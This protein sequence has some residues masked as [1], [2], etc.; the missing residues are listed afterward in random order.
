MNRTA[1][2]GIALLLVACSAPS[3]PGASQ[4]TA[5]LASNSRTFV[6]TAAEGQRGESIIKFDHQCDGVRHQRKVREHI[7]L[8]PDGGARWEIWIEQLMDGALAGST[9]LDL[10][11]R[12]ARRTGS[13]LL[14][15]L[16]GGSGTDFDKPLRIVSATTLSGTSPMGGACRGSPDDSRVVEVTYTLRE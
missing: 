5:L 7:T 16:R 10:A 15:T 6:L 13:T 14:L 11:G 12:W 8:S 9:Y 2:T 1:L 4:F 3:E